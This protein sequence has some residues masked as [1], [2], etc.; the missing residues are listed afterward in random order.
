MPEIEN[1]IVNDTE[2]VTAAEHEARGDEVRGEIAGKEIFVPPVKRWR[3][4]GLKALREGD[5]EQWAE[6]CLSDEAWEVWQ[7]VD[8]TLEEIEAFF[9][10]INDG[11]GVE[12]GNSRSSRR[13]SRTRSRR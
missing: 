6:S 8:P 5:I 2:P 3:S 4:S 10:T 1:D 12:A 13:S 11:L 9:A 7:E